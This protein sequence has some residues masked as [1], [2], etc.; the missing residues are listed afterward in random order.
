M[1]I[2]VVKEFTFDAAHHLP[3][4]D[5]PC[6][7]LHG[8]SYKLQIG[9]RGEVDKPTGMVVDFSELKKVVNKE[10]INKLDHTYLNEVMG[11]FPSYMP[12][13]ENMVQWIVSRLRRMYKLSFVRL[14]ETSTSYAE[15]RREEKC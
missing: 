7:N 12:T 14:Y 3:D 10:I 8:H 15:W 9:V 1:K 6:Q 13:A 11:D 5:G 2:M 4:Y